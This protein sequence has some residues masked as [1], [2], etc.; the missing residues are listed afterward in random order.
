MQC[1]KKLNTII[2]LFFIVKH[3]SVSAFVPYLCSNLFIPTNTTSTTAVVSTYTQA[4]FNT[5]FIIVKNSFLYNSVNLYK[6]TF[7]DTNLSKPSYPVP[8]FFFI[9]FKLNIAL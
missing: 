5:L 9:L 4:Q 6:Y 2:V 3:F 8:V 7:D 1:I